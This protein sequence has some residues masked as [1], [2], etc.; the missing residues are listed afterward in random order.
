M[1][2]YADDTVIYTSTIDR[3]EIERSLQSGFAS[4]QKL[5]SHNKLLLNKKKSCSMMFGTRQGL[6]ESPVLNISF[7]DSSPLEQVSSFKY[8]GLWTDPVLS[9]SEHIKSIINKLSR[10]LGILYC[11]INCFNFQIRKRIVTDC[12]Y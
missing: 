8:L 7:S 10:S 1:H 2:L 4:V 6:S 11:S 3:S 12:L 5:F 9:F